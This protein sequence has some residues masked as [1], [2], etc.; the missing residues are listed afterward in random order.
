MKKLLFI[1]FI[2][3]AA[4]TAKAQMATIFDAHISDSCSSRAGIIGDFSF[5][6]TALTTQFVSKFYN[7]DYIDRESKDAIMGRSR[8]KNRIGAEANYGFFVAVKLDSVMHKKNV[9]FF[10]SLHD[11]YHFDTRYSDDLFKVGFYG[12][13]PFAGKTANLSDFNLTYLHYQ[14][15]QLG[16]FS[17]QSDSTA[18]FGVAF[19]FLKGQQYLAILAKK[20]E[21][22]TS[23]DGQ[24]IDFNTSLQAAQSD[25]AHKG[26]SAFNGYGGSVD[27]FVEAP[28]N[29]RFGKSKIGLSVTDIGVI[30]YNKSSLYLNQDS[31]FHYTGFTIHNI[32]DLQDSAFAHTTTDSV[33][34][35]IAPFKK[36][37]VSVTLPATLN[38]YFQTDFGKHFHLTEGVKYIYNA[39]YNFM[40][41]AKGS[42]YINNNLMLSASFGYGGYG[43]FN[44]GL[45]LFAHVG[46]GV[47]IYAGSN[48]IEGYIAQNQASGMG[49]YISLIKAF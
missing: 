34:N 36:Q 33:K 10:L 23:E 47:F 11:R 21:L 27:V 38:L 19:S 49:G 5:N 17:K 9:H 41:Y 15:L 6:S 1:L 14:Q 40:V 28:F 4:F 8:N 39:N 37:Y 35:K 7:G 48:N 12:N 30:R 24:Y 18:R 2:G 31:L 46:K 16:F 22:Y 44:Y 32:Y 25:T 13:A 42:F 20:A 43:R 29:T 26:M 3:C 45:G